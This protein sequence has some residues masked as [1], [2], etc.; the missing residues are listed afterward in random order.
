VNKSTIDLIK[1]E[2]MKSNNDAKE[3]ILKKKLKKIMQLL[4]MIFLYK[5]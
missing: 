1:K 5:D 3:I 4:I 2:I